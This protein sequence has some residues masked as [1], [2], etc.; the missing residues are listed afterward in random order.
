MGSFSSTMDSS[1]TLDVLKDSEGDLNDPIIDYDELNMSIHDNTDVDSTD[2]G[3]E[4]PPPSPHP[5]FVTTL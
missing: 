1:D 2:V 5:S 4:F 3:C